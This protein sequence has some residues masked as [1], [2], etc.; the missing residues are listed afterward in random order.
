M[1]PVSLATDEVFSTIASFG[2]V[3]GPGA[4]LEA[5][6]ELQGSTAVVTWQHPASSALRVVAYVVQGAVG[7]AGRYAPTGRTDGA[8]LEQRVDDV[9]GQSLRYRVRAKDEGGN[10]GAWVQS[11]AVQLPETF[12]I[13]LRF[14]S[15]FDQN[16]LLHHIGTACDQREYQNP[17]STGDE[18]ASMSSIGKGSPAHFV[19][20]THA[21]P[22]NNFTCNQP[23][24]WM[25]VDLLNRRLVPSHYALRSG[26]VTEK[27]RN[28]ELQ[29]SNDGQAWT[30]LCVHV[31]D[32]SLSEQPMSVA[33][34]PIDAGTIPG[35]SFRH[36]RIL[37]T[38]KNSS[39]HVFLVCAGIELYGLLLDR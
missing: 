24:S 33:A 25:A 4:P 15:P 14:Q 21:K 22:V 9:A 18:V 16:G 35:R 29:A 31:D 2:S 23:S 10:V 5:H 34:W 38:G 12:G 37:Q 19:Q 28:W 13:E 1:I 27:L 36:F 17:H 26:I 6:C 7:D 30:R 3:G 11:P 20:H 8:R 32:R 39:G